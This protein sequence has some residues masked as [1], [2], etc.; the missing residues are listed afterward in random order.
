L[1]SNLKS[2][3]LIPKDFAN[4]QDLRIKHQGATVEVTVVPQLNQGE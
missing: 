1:G 3:S 2:S 4:L